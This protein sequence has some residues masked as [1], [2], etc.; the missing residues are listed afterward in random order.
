MRGARK[1]VINF[2]KTYISL[3]VCFICASVWADELKDIPYSENADAYAQEMCRLD[4]YN[5]GDKP[6]PVFVWF[7]GG[8]ITGGDKKYFP[9]K[10]DAAKNGFVLVSANYRLSPKIKAW[11]AI[12]DCAEAVAWVFKNIDK[13][14]SAKAISEKISEKMS[15]KMS[16][17]EGTNER[18]IE[19]DLAKLKK[20]GILTR[21]G[22]RKEGKWI[23]KIEK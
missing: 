13:I 19:R 21:E 6:K 16:E 1:I 22:G 4:V 20:M 14:G 9:D 8:G 18:T 5:A 11:Q 12:E 23:I 3:F 15:E 10:L 2:M 7:H 17:K